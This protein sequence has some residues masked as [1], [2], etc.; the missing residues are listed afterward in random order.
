MNNNEVEKRREQMSKFSSNKTVWVEIEKVW[1]EAIPVTYDGTSVPFEV[2]L[3]GENVERWFGEYKTEKPIE[4][5]KFKEG[6]YYICMH[7]AWASPVVVIFKNG[8]FTLLD[9]GNKTLVIKETKIGEEIPK[10]LLKGLL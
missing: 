3:V 2:R 4:E 5:R 10:E 6:S 9:S 7:Y 1:H 8:E